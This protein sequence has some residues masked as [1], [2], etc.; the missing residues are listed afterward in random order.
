MKMTYNNTG[1]VNV[2]A[3]SGSDV[4]ISLSYL[5]EIAMSRFTLLVMTLNEGL[6]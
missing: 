1:R 4:A 6:L 5:S 2:I 3:R